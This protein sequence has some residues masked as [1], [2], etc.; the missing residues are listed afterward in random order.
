MARLLGLVVALVCY[1]A[2]FVSFVYLVGFVGGF[3]FM[4]KHV[5]KGLAGSP[6]VSLVVDLGLIALWATPDMT[7]SHVLLA[8]GL[9]V[10]IMIGIA[11]EER[12]LTALYGD[13]YVTYSKRTGAFL[14]GIGKKA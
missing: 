14:P 12:D 13:E 11:H 4:P 3:S 9:T 1:A 6:I 5:D 2:F 10:Y 7:Y 8:A